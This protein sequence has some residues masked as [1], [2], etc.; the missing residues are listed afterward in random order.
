MA[1]RHGSHFQAKHFE[2]IDRA[3][4]DENYFE[5]VLH[6]VG[7]K[8]DFKTAQVLD[9]GC[10]TG[11]FMVPVVA[12]GCTELYGV[13]G[14]TEFA[15]RATRRGYRDVRLVD[16]LSSVELP[17][18]CG[19]FD[20]VVCKDVFE[21]LIN[22]LFALTEIH[23]VLKPGG[24]LLLHVPNHFPLRERL[25]FLITNDIDTF[26][27]FQGESRWTFPHIRFFEYQDSTRT[28]AQHGF[29]VVA[30][31]SHYFQSFPF[32]P[33]IRLLMPFRRWLVSQFP[34]QFA[35][36]FTFLARRLD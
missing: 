35:S 10:G 30:D 36:A 33:R 21:H 1:E 29:T 24:L 11:I 20:L 23:R 4:Q 26:S 18:E 17:F 2:N 5:P 22:P 19:R 13:D 34:N 31:L 9:V 15:D 7:R 12:A 16:D 27:F 3:S 14:P 28:L 8:V 6:D 32:L 25:K